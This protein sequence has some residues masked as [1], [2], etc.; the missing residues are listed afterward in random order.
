MEKKKS[1]QS[2]RIWLNI[3]E[4]DNGQEIVTINKSIMHNGKWKSSPF[5][6]VN[7]GDIANV[8]QAIERY[9]E[10]IEEVVVQ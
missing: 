1:F 5:F 9:E 4:T 2:G 8:K 10:S 3:F 6:N 7:K